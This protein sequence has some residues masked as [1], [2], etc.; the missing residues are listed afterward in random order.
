MIMVDQV[1][2]IVPCVGL[3]SMNQTQKGNHV[4]T[5]SKKVIS[6]KIFDKY[7]NS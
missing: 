7:C 4:I 2:K 1:P 5:F 6:L 3:S